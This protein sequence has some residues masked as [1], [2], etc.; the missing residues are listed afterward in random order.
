M[1]ATWNTSPSDLGKRYASIASAIPDA[2]HDVCANGASKWE[3]RAKEIATWIDRTGHARGGL[4]GEARRQGMNTI[5]ICYGTMEYQPYL[6]LGTSMMAARPSIV[7]AMMEI[8]P[9]IL[10]DAQTVVTRLLGGK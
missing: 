6:E 10:Q 2:V 4:K 8:A 5:V 3:R 9:G 7:P 1:A